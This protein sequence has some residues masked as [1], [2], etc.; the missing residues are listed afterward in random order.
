MDTKWVYETYGEMSMKI[1]R[2]SILNF[3]SFYNLELSDL[4]GLHLVSGPT[5]SGKST[6][7]DSIYWILFGKT[8]KGIKVDS[9]RNWG[10]LNDITQGTLN[11]SLSNKSTLSITRT[12]GSSPKDNDLIM[13]EGEYSH[14][15]RG[16]DMNETQEFINRTLGFD[17]AQFE[18]AAYLHEFSQTGTFFNLKPSQQKEVFETIA[19]LSFPIELK[20]KLKT[21][22]TSVGR[23][24]SAL[25]S[26]I[27]TLNT[28]IEVLSKRISQYKV[29]SENF[30]ADQIK[31]Y[32]RDEKERSQWFAGQLAKFDKK[33]LDSVS[34]LYELENGSKA[35]CPTCGEEPES[36]AQSIRTQQLYH[37]N[38]IKE[39]QKFIEN[40]SMSLAL[41][42]PLNNQ[43]EALIH[44]DSSDL[45]VLDKK[46]EKAKEQLKTTENKEN[47]LSTLVDLCQVL[48]AELLKNAIIQIQTKTNYFLA[49]YFESELQVKFELEGEEN[50]KTIILK[51]GYECFER[52][53]SKGQRCLLKLCF[54]LAMMEEAGSHCLTHFDTLCFDEA[55]DGLDSEFKIKSYRLFEFLS[56]KHSCILVVDHSSE[57]QSLFDNKIEVRLEG[58]ASHILLR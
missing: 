10:S 34:R 29:A 35:V 44:M 25:E 7:L 4:N 37:R 14:L 42:E 57:L 52:Q 51:Q 36:N 12:R 21:R 56:T 55:L 5:G 3:G 38:L 24:V 53:L 50:F 26:D 39:K 18:A 41:P 17:S 2:L 46:L 33:V 32:D 11:I 58:D 8:S 19:D 49:E 27:K 45:Q 40:E 9:V 47:E 16:K 54:S 23:E 30:E 6:I 43:Y 48:K 1:N 13:Y 28:K 22:Q 15:K 31:K 20:T